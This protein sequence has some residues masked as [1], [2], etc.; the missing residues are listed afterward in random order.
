MSDLLV[1][2][3]GLRI[4]FGGAT[5]VDGVSFEVRA[6]ECLALVGES[7][8]GKTLTSR[9]LLG[10][11]PSPGV[12]SAD[13]LDVA[14]TDTR[15]F[16]ESRWRD[17]RGRQVGL[18]AQDALV[19][20][21]PLRTIG[22]E[23]GEVLRVHSRR[24]RQQLSHD[25]LA[26]AVVE[27]LA[28]VAIPSPRERSKQHAH[29][30]SGG[31][32]QRALIAAATIARPRLLI[33]DEPT[34]AL[35]LRVQSQVLDLLARLKGNGAGI[36]LIS[37]DLA[38]VARIADRIAVM[39]G[40][41]IV[42]TGAT[43]IVLGEPE[44][45]YTRALLNATPSLHKKGARLSTLPRPEATLAA[46]VIDPE[47]TVLSVR[48]VSKSFRQPSGAQIRA[49]DDVSFELTEG[50]T[51]GIVGES[52]SG[53]TTLG[54]IIL[55]LQQP[56]AGE[57]FLD[58]QQ[59]SHVA[60][61]ARRSRRHSIQAVYQD[62]LS[63]FDPRLTAGS[64]LQESLALS[65]VPRADRRERAVQLADQVGL[66]PDLLRRLP[67]AL[68]GGQRQRVAI[69]RAL[70]RN[71]RVLLCDEPVSALDV[72]I[73]AQVLDLFADIQTELGLSTVFISHDLGVIRHVS[74][75]VLVM[76]DGVVV[77]RGSTEAVF[78]DPQHSYT[79]ELLSALPIPEATTQGIRQ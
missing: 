17:L 66:A 50:R 71:P 60:E 11:V 6:G 5:V 48:G 41:H 23:V 32:R 31:L 70:A 24:E 75:E 9:S 56:D 29:E 55:G 21:D 34:T 7:G 69:A 26:S 15:A 54:R 4:S 28:R 3:E 27:E 65:G 49:V 25:A 62:P 16:D 40:G 67:F 14:G 42:E 57:V 10:L 13:R 38:V 64:I 58:E 46:A 20:L 77:E 78:T 33:A 8:S 73:Q 19:S 47:R 2:V 61:R 37:H 76:R 22:R 39:R 44:H 12:V 51:V 72:S 68:S 18:V 74:D 63:S 43:S 36:L 52:G 30:L 35:D 53:K 1:N 45:E 59:W 79:Q